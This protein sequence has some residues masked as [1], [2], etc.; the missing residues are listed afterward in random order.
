MA[1]QQYRVPPGD[2]FAYPENGPIDPANADAFA[3]YKHLRDDDC[4]RHRRYI[5]RMWKRYYAL[6]LH[7]PKFEKSFPDECPSRIWEMHLA[8]VFHAWGWLL[9][10]SAKRGS[11]FDFGVRG[12]DPS[13]NATM[14]IEATAPGRGSGANVT[15]WTPGPFGVGYANGGELQRTQSLRFAQVIQEKRGQYVRALKNGL[16]TGDDGFVVAISGS[17]WDNTADVGSIDGPPVIVRYLFGLGGSTY[18]V[19]LGGE[20]RVTQGPFRQA[21]TI[22]KRT[23]VG[24]D[25]ATQAGLFATAACPDI[26]AVIFCPNH[27]K[28][29]PR[30]VGG[31]LSIIHNPFARVPFP[32]AGLRR[33]EEWWIEETEH[34]ADLLRTIVEHGEESS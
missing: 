20:R 12:F 25:D 22:Q 6:G 26:S 10:P 28:N 24:V 4:E 5:R 3:V 34:G 21:L 19:E 32:R 8:F 18:N 16:V 33:G 13:I 2:L 31:D 14:W 29:R 30:R 17:R 11:G 27:I 23:P 7:D 9:V 1:K 15:G